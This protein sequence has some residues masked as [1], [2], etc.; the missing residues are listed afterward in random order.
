MQ[1]AAS[2]S[3]QRCGL[4]GCWAH[5]PVK[6]LRGTC[7]QAGAPNSEQTGLPPLCPNH[8]TGLGS[9]DARAVGQ[10]VISVGLETLR[11]AGAPG[12]GPGAQRAVLGMLGSQQLDAEELGLSGLVR[13]ML[14]GPV[15]AA[16]RAAVLLRGTSESRPEN[17]RMSGRR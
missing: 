11:A 10:H 5:K 13:R 8:V 17:A 1:K 14:R 3:K 7:R 4:G 6:R 9:L 2:P 15:L 12:H 16:D